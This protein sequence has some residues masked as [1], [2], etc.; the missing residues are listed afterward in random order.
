MSARPIPESPRFRAMQRQDL[1]SIMWIEK[2][3]YSYPWSKGVF[4]DCLSAGYGCRLMEYHGYPVGYAVLSVAL[5]EAHL[6]NLCIDPDW[7]GRGLAGQLLSH[8]SEQA[9]FAG[10][11]SLFLEVRP[12]NAV[13]LRLYRSFGFCEVG[14]RRGYY[15]AAGGREDAL[16]MALTLMN[17]SVASWPP[18]A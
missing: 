8:M 13:A 3:A 15:P 18:R 16:I 4:K 17:E 2:R 1:G 9:A 10:A 6:L 7:Q 5:D 12:S 11:T 14:T